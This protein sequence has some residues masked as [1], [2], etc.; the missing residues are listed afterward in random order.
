M[1]GVISGAFGAH[2][3]EQH[4][5]PERLQTWGKAVDYL[6][7]HALGLILLGVLDAHEP[8]KCH[9]VAGALMLVGI[10]LFSGSLFVLVLSDIR[11]LGMIT[12]LGGVSFVAA[13]LVLGG[14]YLLPDKDGP[15]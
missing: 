11:W 6:F 4:V 13:W 10:V 7:I 12:P 14:C 9:R 3:L 5:T 8:K 2:A 1:T 15:A